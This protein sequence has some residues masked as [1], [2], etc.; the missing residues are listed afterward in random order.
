MVPETSALTRVSLVFMQGET[1]VRIRF[2]DAYPGSG[3]AKLGDHESKFFSSLQL[4]SRGNCPDV[5]V[6]LIIIYLH[7][8]YN[9]SYLHI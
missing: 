5:N 7:L 2:R 3:S 9:F 1:V 4:G 8:D 6:N